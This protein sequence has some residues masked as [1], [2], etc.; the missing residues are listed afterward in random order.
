MLRQ[1]RVSLFVQFNSSLAAVPSL[2]ERDR[3]PPVEGLDELSLAHRLGDEQAPDPQLDQAA[4]Q[5]RNLV[6][7]VHEELAVKLAEPKPRRLGEL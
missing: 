5:R 2:I 3:V 1:V 7:R 4:H 6:A